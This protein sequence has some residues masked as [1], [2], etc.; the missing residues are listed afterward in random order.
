MFRKDE[1][2]LGITQTGSRAFD[3]VASD[4]QLVTEA[5][6]ITCRILR[7]DARRPHQRCAAAPS[8]DQGRLR[9]T[10]LP[11]PLRRLLTHDPGAGKAIMAGLYIKELILRDDVRKRLIVAPGGLTRRIIE[12]GCT[13]VV[14]NPSET[15]DQ[16]SSTS[17]DA[18]SAKACPQSRLAEGKGKSAILSLTM[19]QTGTKQR[20]ASSQRADAARRTG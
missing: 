7:P 14:V 10:A 13:P 15:H 3:A 2:T 9:G 18:S 4:V 16:P 1:G 11:T 20:H 17:P 19:K 5:Q 12:A 8:L 6:R